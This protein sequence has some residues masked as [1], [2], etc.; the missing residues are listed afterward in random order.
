MNDFDIDA[1]R[2]TVRSSGTVL[3][4]AGPPRDRCAEACRVH[5][6][7]VAHDPVADRGLPAPLVEAADD[8]VAAAKLGGAGMPR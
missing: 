1:M 5:Q 8:L 4:V 3:P 6:L 7:A 2:N